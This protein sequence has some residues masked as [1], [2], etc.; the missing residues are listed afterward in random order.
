MR[1]KFQRLYKSKVL[2]SG[3][4]RRIKKIIDVAMRVLYIDVRNVFVV[5]MLRVLV[6]VQCQYYVF[7]RQNAAEKQQQK[8][9]YVVTEGAHSLK[10]IKQRYRKARR[11]VVVVSRIKPWQLKQSRRE[12]KLLRSISGRQA[13]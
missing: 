1:G 10:R 11:M 9:R 6:A 13:T 3:L 4:E 12:Q 7:R 2:R 8:I 5:F